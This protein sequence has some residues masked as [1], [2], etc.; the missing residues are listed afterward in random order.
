MKASRNLLILLC[1]VCLMLQ[2]ALTHF[3]C[4]NSFPLHSLD[5]QFHYKV[6]MSS[7]R[8]NS[9]APLQVVN[10][11]VPLGRCL[12]SLLLWL[13]LSKLNAMM[14]FDLSYACTWV[15]IYSSQQSSRA[16]NCRVAPAPCELVL[17][18]L[19]VDQSTHK[20]C[21]WES[22]FAH[23]PFEMQHKSVS[24]GKR[25]GFQGQSA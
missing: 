15:H 3:L 12:C 1:M 11:A 17:P 8:I 16:G 24:Q 5:S 20:S 21:Q 9:D 7:M 6:P 18:F 13:V 4:G 14:W 25:I 22:N 2:T 23:N 19:A 10:A